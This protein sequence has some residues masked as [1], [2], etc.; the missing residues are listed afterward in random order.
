MKRACHKEDAENVSCHF[1]TMIVGITL[2]R[3][4]AYET[5]TQND[6]REI[7]GDKF[8]NWTFDVT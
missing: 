5:Q 1:I 4:M 6:W 7:L 8:P 3:L 2:A